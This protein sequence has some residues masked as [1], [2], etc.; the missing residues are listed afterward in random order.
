MMGWNR[1]ERERERERGWMDCAVEI[2]PSKVNTTFGRDSMFQ[3]GSNEK[4]ERKSQ[5][6][7]AF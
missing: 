7:G 2:R 4:R 6:L 1:G 5:I 3:N